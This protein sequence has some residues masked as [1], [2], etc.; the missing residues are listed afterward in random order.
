MAKVCPVCGVVIRDWH[1]HRE[2]YRKMGVEKVGLFK[3]K[4]TI[5]RTTRCFRQHVRKIHKDRKKGISAGHGVPFSQ[6]Y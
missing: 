4:K 5:I 3:H 6:G 2:G 1:R